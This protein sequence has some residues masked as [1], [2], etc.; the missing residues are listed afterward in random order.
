MTRLF[1]IVS[2]ISFFGLMA[3]LIAWILLPERSPQFPIATLLAIALIPLLFPLRGL[4]H[5]KPYTYAW[6]SFLMLFYFTHA[7]GELYSVQRFD[8][9]ASFAVLFSSLCFISSILFIRYKAK[10]DEQVSNFTR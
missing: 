3:T 4:L 10:N 7:V 2:L 5:G 1:R 9:Y 6:N 8:S